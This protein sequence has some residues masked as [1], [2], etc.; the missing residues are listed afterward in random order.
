MGDVD[1]DGDLDFLAANQGNDN[2]SVRLNDGSGSFS[3]TTNV[4]VGTCPFSVAVGDVDGDGDLDLLTANN[5][6]NT[7]S[8]RL[9][10]LPP[11]TITGFSAVDNTVCVGSPIS[12]TATVGNVTGTY[13]FTLSNGTSPLS[14]TATGTAF[15]QSLT[16]S[17]SGTQSFTLTV[18]DNGQTATATATVTVTAAPS[19][20]ISYPGSPFLTSSGPVS[21]SQTGTVGGTY[22]SSPTGLS[23]NTNTGQITPA[24]SNP[25]SYTVTYAIA[26]SQG[27]AAFS[28]TASVGIQELQADLGITC[29]NGV[30]T[31]QAGGG[32]T[33]TIT[34]SNVGPSNAPGALVEDTF[35]PNLTGVSWMAVGSGGGSVAGASSGTGNINQRV[36]LPPGGSVIFTVTATVS[37]SA[38]GT[39]VNTATVTA[40]AGVTDPFAGNN[41]ATDTDTIT[42]PSPTI[43]GFAAVDNSVCVG[44]PLTFTATVGNVTGAY[45][46][47]LSNGSSPLSGTATGSAF[48]QS[49]V[50][51]G[52]GP[53][54]FTLTVGD[55]GFQA[56]ATTPVTVNALP[57]AGLTNNGPLTCS[58]TSVTLTASGGSSYTFTSPGGGVLAGS[59]NTRVVSSPGSYSVQVSDG[60]GCSASATTS[61]TAN[62][63]LPTASLTNNGPITCSMTSVTLTAS[64]GASYRFSAGATQIGTANR[65][66]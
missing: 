56:T 51:S 65:L 45:A 5:G 35:V 11:P 20:T 60:N 28:T 62:Q 3:G 66:R 19:A 9:N 52:N 40:P 64:G 1:G 37:S 34:V 15:S 36:N 48:S 4:G 6:S 63:T 61:V 33:Y 24:S 53:Q 47:T 22:S 32:V 54:S 29:T 8:V 12:F 21:V 17:G 50:A 30:A 59:G 27:C 7:V 13:S 44:S 25:G 10:Q 23:L 2:V 18:G 57:I 38:T 42:P 16:A 46:F 41:S 31:V 49:L 58:Q 43:T 26:A 55:N 39:L 14:G